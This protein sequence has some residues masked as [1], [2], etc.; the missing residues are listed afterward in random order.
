M[1]IN[2]R[3]LSEVQIV[4]IR[5]ALRLGTGVDSFRQTI[6]DAMAAGISRRARLAVGE[7]GDSVLD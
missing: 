3:R 5:G 2:V 1:E 6:D 4:Q 7:E